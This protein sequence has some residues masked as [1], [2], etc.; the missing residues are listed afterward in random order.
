[1]PFSARL[2]LPSLASAA[3]S[4]PRPWIRRLVVALVALAGLLAATACGA[5]TTIAGHTP[6]PTVSSTTQ[7]AGALYVLTTN[8]G[9]PP[10]STT[11]YALGLSNG[12]PRWHVQVTGGG[13]VT[14]AL[15]SATLYVG[16]VQV[17]NSGQPTGSTVE[18]LTTRTGAQSWQHA[19]AAV[20]LPVAANADAVYVDKVTFTPTGATAA[21]TIEALRASDGTP[22]WSAA[23]TG[24]PDGPATLG[25]GVLYV[26]TASGA[27]GDF[28]DPPD[29]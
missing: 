16:T 7:A 26:V 17:S 10:L 28:H 12:Q 11:V 29:V 25:D 1:M 18:A 14:M 27:Y 5:S 15:G 6:T 21:S 3:V 8:A 13:G 19:Y 22:V 4:L 23:L 9:A 20:A 2:Q 24:P